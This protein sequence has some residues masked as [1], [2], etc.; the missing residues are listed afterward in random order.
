MKDGIRG[1]LFDIGGVLVTLDGVPS[2]A[3]LL[4][5]EA[6]HE[7]IHALWL[8]SPSVVAH[9]TGKISMEKFAAGVVADL[10]LPIAPDAFLQDFCAWPGAVKPGTFEL[11]D[12]IPDRYRVAALSNTSAAHW[13]RIKTMGLARRFERT[14]LSHETGCLKP[15]HEAFWFALNDM[16]LSPADVVFL[17]DSASNVHAARALGIHAHLARDPQEAMAV[18]EEYGVTR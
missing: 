15:G 2:L 7:A 13:D 10:H 6:S 8:S 3:K 4:R 12:A 17:D 9:E 1:V 11:L 16:G 5:I 14:Y 18:L